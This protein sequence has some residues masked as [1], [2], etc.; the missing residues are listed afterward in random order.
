MTERRLTVLAVDDEPMLLTTFTRLLR[1]QFDIKTAASGQ[2]A[3]VML[4]SE[5]PDVLVSDF[6]MPGMNGIELLTEVAARHPK[7]VRLLSTAHASLPELL[8]AQKAGL[9]SELVEK[10]WTREMMRA[11]IE[12]SF[13][14]GS[15]SSLG[16][17]E[18]AAPADTNA[19]GRVP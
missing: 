13:Q 12:R 5:Q 9:F 1:G 11:A 18:G 19:A 4:E 6:A 2:A 10:P 3:L 16:E 7:V 15:E 17:G 8:A 14:T